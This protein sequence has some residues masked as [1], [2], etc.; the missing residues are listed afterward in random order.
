[1]EIQRRHLQF[2]GDGNLQNVVIR[3]LALPSLYGSF[4]RDDDCLI[5]AQASPP[6]GERSQTKTDP[7]PL[8]AACPAS[9][10]AA[11]RARSGTPPS[12][13]GSPLRT[14]FRE[15]FSSRLTALSQNL[16]IVAAAA[17][18]ARLKK[19]AGL[20]PPELSALPIA[21][22]VTEATANSYPAIARWP[23]AAAAR[24]IA[25]W[26][27]AVIAAAAA[28]AIVA[29]A[30]GANRSGGALSGYG[31]GVCVPGRVYRGKRGRAL[32]GCKTK[33][34]SGCRIKSDVSFSHL[35]P[36]CCEC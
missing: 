30:A 20:R 23:S 25:E 24:A 12:P 22:R 4:G 21:V 1:M 2:M 28:A 18:H 16:S 11:H 8:T 33:D 31:L 35:R 29:S 7:S 5:F 27:S 32:R 17:L 36:A 15:C 9:A 13:G 6:P 3:T 14:A 26:P 19:R 34:E 10:Q